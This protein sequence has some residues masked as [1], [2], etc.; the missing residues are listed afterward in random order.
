MKDRFNIDVRIFSEVTSVNSK[1]KKVTVKNKNGESY[2]ESYDF[3]VLFPGASAISLNLIFSEEGKIFE[4]QS[5][6]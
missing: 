5:V 6:E 2:E 1:E 3:P 4:A